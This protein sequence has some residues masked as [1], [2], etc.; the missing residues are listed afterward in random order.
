MADRD[1][2]ESG[3]DIPK[4]DP[5]VAE[6]PQ[7]VLEL[8]AELGNVVKRANKTLRQVVGTLC[9]IIVL[10]LGAVGY[11]LVENAKSTQQI[12][13]TVDRAVSSDC[14]FFYEVGTLT[15]I[16]PPNPHA[17]SRLAAQLVISGRDTFLGQHCPGSMGKPSSALRILASEFQIPL[18]G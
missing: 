1:Q 3:K 11:L 9:V 2:A 5:A 12:S 4:P 6:G 13:D 14:G 7:P 10:L 17:S 8:D 18:R 15:L 16:A